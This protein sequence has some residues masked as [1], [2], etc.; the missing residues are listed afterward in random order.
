MSVEE[1]ATIIVF[2]KAGMKIK[3]IIAHTGCNTTTIT[4][5]LA[6]TRVLGDQ[7]LPRGRRGLAGSEK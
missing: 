6:A 5:I 4:R 3:D 2:R 7:G 1:K